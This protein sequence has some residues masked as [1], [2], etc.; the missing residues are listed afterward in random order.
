VPLLQLLKS[1]GTQLLFAEYGCRPVAWCWCKLVCI[2][3]NRVLQTRHALLRE[4]FRGV[5]SED[6][7]HVVQL[8]PTSRDH[9]WCFEMLRMLRKCV[10]ATALA[11]CLAVAKGRWQDVSQVDV[12]IVLQAWKNAWWVWPRDADPRHSSGTA[13]AYRQWMS[14]N[15]DHFAPYVR[16]CR[17]INGLHTA[18]LVSVGVHHL[19]VSKGRR[20]HV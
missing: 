13:A 19:E 7:A 2:Y 4:A 12:A 5:T 18:A 11:V 8:R 20:N 3:W 15:V 14:T 17:P 1:V 10:P 9:S 6:L 16:A